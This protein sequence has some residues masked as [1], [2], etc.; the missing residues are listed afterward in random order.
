MRIG[1]GQFDESI[2]TYD[3]VLKT[4]PEF[5]LAISGKANVL[6]RR[7]QHEQARALLEPYIAA[8]REDGYMAMVYAQA[9]LAAG[10]HQEC[11]ALAARHL[12][13]R[14]LDLVNRRIL[15]E[16][17]AKAYEKLGDYAKA[18]EAY[19]KSNEITAIPFDPAKY[20]AEVDEIISLFSAENMA[21]LPRASNASEAPVF[22]ASMPRSGS[23]LVEQIIHAHP[24]AFGAGEIT[25][26][27][28]IVVNLPER[29]GSFQRYPM[30]LGDFTQA[31]ADALA[32]EYLAEL[33]SRNRTA[34]RIANKHLL[35][36]RYL[37]MVALLFPKARVIHVQREAMDNC[38]S[39]FMAS[40][41]PRSHPYA[42]NLSNLGLA[43]RQHL[44]L[45]EHWTAALDI[46]IL[47][48]EYE[49]LVA[50]PEKEIRRLIDFL[51]LEWDDRCMKFHEV[52][53][54]VLT[55]SYDQVNKPM[56]SSAVKRYEK[57]EAH[58]APLRAALGNPA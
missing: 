57:Y 18:F 11:I 30:C 8:G 53:R 46:P 38:F 27:Q 5:A 26:F 56:Y 9:Q 3:R 23:T 6:M 37:G 35:N 17:I 29:I 12:N 1:Q 49:T 41:D 58:L 55:L 15:L 50:E 32:E 40:L 45:M 10:E 28:D 52:K 47:H 39:C 14:Q 20:V 4:N 24:K 51:G 22:I 31:H 25:E 7:G 34:S 48:V 19:T 43:Y 16:L 13:D 2:R 36:Y 44:R 42:T 33:K 54:D 21:R